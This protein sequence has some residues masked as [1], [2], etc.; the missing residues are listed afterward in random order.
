MT[1]DD[2]KRLTTTCALSGQIYEHLVNGKR[3]KYKIHC[4][5]KNLKIMEQPVIEEHRF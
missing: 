2:M 5:P 3:T 1:S 4:D